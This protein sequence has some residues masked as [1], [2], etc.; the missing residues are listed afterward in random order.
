MIGRLA[1][2]YQGEVLVEY[3]GHPPVP[4]K[5]VAGLDRGTLLQHG[6]RGREVLLL[7]EQGDPRLPII[8]A[9]MEDRLESLIDLMPSE[10]DN[11]PLHAVVDGETVTI[12]AEREILLKCGEGSIH[13]RRDGKIIVKGTDILS[14]SSGRQRIRGASVNIN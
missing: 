5:L 10:A 8:V 7:F 2:S 3:Y 12:E 11:R 1:G 6:Q 13:I 4:A 9:L 14:R